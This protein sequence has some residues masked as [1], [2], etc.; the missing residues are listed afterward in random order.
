[1]CVSPFPAAPPV[2]VFLMLIIIIIISVVRPQY[3]VYSGIAHMVSITG[4]NPAGIAFFKFFLVPTAVSS[5][6]Y[7][8]A[9]GAVL[10]YPVAVGA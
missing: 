6:R 8:V 7:P 5:E 10:R 3:Y 4:S 1:M 2:G 9:V